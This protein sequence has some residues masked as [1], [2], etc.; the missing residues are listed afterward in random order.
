MSILESAFEG[1]C[2]FTLRGILFLT[3]LDPSDFEEEEEVE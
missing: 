2:S 3:A 1:L